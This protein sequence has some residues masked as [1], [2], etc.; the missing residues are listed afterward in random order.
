MTAEAERRA[1]RFLSRSPLLHADMAAMVLSG[2]CGILSADDGGVLLRYGG[3]YMM[4]ALSR[5]TADAMLAMIP[6][7][8]L[9]DAHQ[10]FYVAA[11]REKF[12]LRTVM[13]CRQAVY[14]RK[15]PLPPVHFPAE[16]RPVGEE[17]L[18]FLTKHY[19]HADINGEGYLR[20][21]L[22]SGDFFA[23]FVGGEP[24]GFIGTH[25][26]GSMGLLEVLPRYRRRG[27][28]AALATMQ[29]NRLLALGRVPFSQIEPE[30]AAS[31]ALH[32]RLGFA[33]SDESLYWLF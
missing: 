26:E 19:T 27:V 18:P 31:F 8:E 23:A 24:A 16:I 17:F 22:R 11:A 3:G 33:V 1:L 15:E 7:A 28:A 9:L 25:E 32:R 5:R 30:N 12:G 4:S 13:E 10:R 2:R 29:T 21:R 20:E 6:R 14:T